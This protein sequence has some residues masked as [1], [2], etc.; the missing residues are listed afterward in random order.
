MLC[1]MLFN[2]VHGNQLVVPHMNFAYLRAQTAAFM[3]MQSATRS[4]LGAR[5]SSRRAAFATEMWQ[6]IDEGNDYLMRVCFS[7]EATYHTWGKINRHNARVWGL[8]TPRV[9]LENER[10]SQKLYVWCALMHNNV[11][12]PFFFSECTISAVVYLDMMELYA[13]PQKS[14]C[15]G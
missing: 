10:D 7:D 15:H 9:V 1:V 5:R 8:E 3:R 4:S 14:F 6:R 12:G 2:A 11:I 13:A